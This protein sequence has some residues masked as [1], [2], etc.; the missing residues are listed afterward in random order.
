MTNFNIKVISDPV[1]PFCYLGKARLNR[2]IDVYKKTYPAGKDD[3]FNVTWQAY[4]LDPTAPKKGVPVNERMAARFG[5]ERLEMMH[6]R[7]KKL[8]AA[9]GF[10]FT[11]DGKVGHTRDAHRAVQLAKTKGPEVENAVMTSIM[12]SYFEEGG[13]VTSWD[14][15]VD[16]AVKGGLEKEEVKK[17][18]EEG[19]GG[20]EVDK[21][22]EDAYRKGVRGVPHFVINDKYEIGGAQDVGEF[23]ETLVAAKQGGGGSNGQDGLTC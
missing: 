5:A 21:Q 3:N 12:K 9:E 23:L 10:N 11:F 7:M 14:M 19:K 1:C 2:A 4:Y 8:G 15:I 17:W 16:A 18:L 20:A 13:D 6:D 22:V